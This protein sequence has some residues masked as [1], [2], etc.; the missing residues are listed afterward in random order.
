[1]IYIIILLNFFKIIEKKFLQ[2]LKIFYIPKIEK[3]LRN[4]SI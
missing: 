4:S 3:I 2:V 1:M